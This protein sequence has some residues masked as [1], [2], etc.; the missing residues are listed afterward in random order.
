MLFLAGG[1]GY[2]LFLDNGKQ[3]LSSFNPFV[4]MHNSANEDT[5]PVDDSFLYPADTAAASQDTGEIVADTAWPA[6][7]EP[8]LTEE[9]VSSTEPIQPAPDFGTTADS[10]AENPPAK[11]TKVSEKI[12]ETAPKSTTTSKAPEVEAGFASPSTPPRYYV[13]V[14][15]FGVKKNAHK[16]RNKLINKGNTDAKLILPPADKNL[17]KVSV[18]DYSTFQE[19]AAKADELKSE[20]GN[21]VWVFKY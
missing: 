1:A 20:F 7:A 6:I 3:A 2:F 15:G 19:A 4:S 8:V 10:P 12:V 14:G 18:A 11:T 9:A 5:G 17:L 16:L 13:I 21:S